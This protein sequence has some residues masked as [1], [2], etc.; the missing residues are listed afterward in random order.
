[1]V[2]DPTWTQVMILWFVGLSPKSGSVSLELRAWSLLQIL[3]IPLSLPLSCSCFLSLSLSV[4]NIKKFKDEETK[5]TDGT[6][7]RLNRYLTRELMFLLLCQPCVLINRRWQNLGEKQEA[8][9]SLF[10][11]LLK[12]SWAGSEKKQHSRCER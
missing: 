1:M 8:L 4:K 6:F 9:A 10:C 12:S 11:F 5:T 2:K 3:F 7:S